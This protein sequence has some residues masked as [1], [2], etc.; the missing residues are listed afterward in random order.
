M[1]PIGDEKAKAKEPRSKGKVSP[2]KYWYPAIYTARMRYAESDRWVAFR[3]DLCFPKWE[4]AHAHSVL[5][6][7]KRVERAKSDLAAAIRHLG[8]VQAMVKPADADA[9]PATPA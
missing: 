5:L 3:K 6:A 1:T 9:P 7:Q 2:P 8:R 4:E